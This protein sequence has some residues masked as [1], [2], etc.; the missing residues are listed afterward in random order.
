MNKQQQP[1]LDIMAELEK[2]K[3]KRERKTLSSTW[4]GIS[5]LIT[6]GADLSMGKIRNQDPAWL[7]RTVKTFW[8]F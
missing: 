7:Q 3:K 8:M 1:E 6:F 2:E 5:R 4:R